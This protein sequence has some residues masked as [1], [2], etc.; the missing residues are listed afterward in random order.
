MKPDPEITQL[1]QVI[2][3]LIVGAVLAYNF[4]IGPIILGA[5]GILIIGTFILAKK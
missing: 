3:G 5:L 1:Y 4:S 2:I